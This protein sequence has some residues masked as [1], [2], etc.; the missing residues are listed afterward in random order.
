MLKRSSK[1]YNFIQKISSE[2]QPTK[3]LRLHHFR[4]PA[5]TFA[6]AIRTDVVNGF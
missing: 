4:N 2:P 6:Q 3:I 5:E 1:M